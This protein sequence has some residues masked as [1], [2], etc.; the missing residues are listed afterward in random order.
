[1]TPAFHL[2]SSAGTIILNDKT[3]NISHDSVTFTLTAEES[4]ISYIDGFDTLIE[5]EGI[6]Y[7]L[8]YN[9]GNDT[10]VLEE[11]V[12]EIDTLVYRVV[13][14]TDETYTFKNLSEPF[15]VYT[16]DASDMVDIEEAANP[17][18]DLLDTFCRFVLLALFQFS[19]NGI[20]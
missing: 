13:H 14:N 11:K 18:P 9:A 17:V 4:W 16:T 2:T 15:G 7:K 6:L 12:V 19:K 8:T 10:I 1:M 5:V 20:D 3:Y